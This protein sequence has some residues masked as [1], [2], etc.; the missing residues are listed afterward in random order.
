MH[1][2]S[3]TG[4]DGSL[5][6]MGRTVRQRPLLAVLVVLALGGVVAFL[7][8]GSEAGNPSYRLAKVERGPIS[9]KVAASGTLNAV[10]TVTVGSQVSGKIKE[11]NADFNTEVK[12][13]QV[14]ARID[15]VPFEANVRQAQADLLLAKA[16]V[17]NATAGVAAAQ[18]EIDR[19]AAAAVQAK[20]DLD[21]KR[22]L[23]AKGVYAQ[24][25]VDTAV[26]VEDQAVATLNSAKAKLL[27]TQA[28]VE[29]A[30]ATVA[31]KD[32]ALNQV[33]FNLDNSIIRSP[34]DGVVIGRSVDVGQTVAASLQAP[35]L[36][37]IAQNLR[38][39]QVEVS[40]D[41]ADIG[42]IREG[43]PTSFTVDSFPGHNFPGTV[44]QIRKAPTVV[45]NVVT[46][47]VVVSA[48]NPQLQLLPGMTA[49]V[50]VMVEEK[51]STLKIANAALRFR[52]AG[53]TDAPGGAAAAETESGAG[54]SNGGPNGGPPNI[55]ALLA[56][57][58]KSLTLTD[59]QQKQI[60]GI[61]TEARDKVAAARQRG[62]PPEDM[63]AEAQKAREES[64]QAISA[65]L[66][67]E[68]RE[69]YQA[70]QGN[71]QAQQSRR[72]TVWVIGA[73]GKPAAVSIVTGM[74]DGATTEIVR[75]D[76]KEGQAVI[77]GTAAPG[78]GG[79]ASNS[80]RG[81]PRLGF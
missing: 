30:E 53:A 79:A 54:G 58:T 57:M 47:T 15:P 36:F 8:A 20:Q 22:V 23:M 73:N 6:R 37:T 77:V 25:V 16:N 59:D 10:V 60:R 4:S 72:G 48:E 64:R 32:A 34:V 18:A 68:Q 67:D 9:S 56:R 46:Y 51:D 63:R 45:Q 38:K 69:K 75:G 61:M 27:Q 29:T 19:S 50:Q 2:V 52:P 80:S 65:L 74:T 14:I 49:N 1:G 44:T 43:Q 28:Q 76:L 62:L 39:M 42:R 12:A 26:A 11:L 71:R 3:P 13:G 70:A 17:S 35:V 7:T 40:V 66:T 55:D 41:E 33:Q 21:R 78:T 24:S 31:M 5:K 81:G